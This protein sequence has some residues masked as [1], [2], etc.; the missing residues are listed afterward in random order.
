MKNLLRPV[1]V[2]VLLVGWHAVFCQCIINSADTTTGFTPNSPAIIMPGVP[3]SQT[4]QV[5]VPATYNVYTVDS[6]HIDSLTGQPSGI[7][8][9]LNPASGTVPGGSGGA[10]CFTGTT[11]D[12]V[13]PYPLTF[14]GLAYTNGG[15]IPFSYLTTLDPNFG[16]KFRIETAPAAIFTVDSPL[17][18]NLDTVKFVDHTTGYPTHWKWTFTGGTPATSTRQFPAVVYAS[19]G[20]YPVKFVA[21]NSISN[22]T[23][24]DT[25]TV[26]PSVYVDVAARPA[27]GD[28]SASNGSAIAIPNGGTPP[29]NYAWSNGAYGDTMMNVTSGIYMLT[30][31]DAK[32]CM[33]TNDSVVI[34]FVFDG[35]VQLSAKQQVKIYPNPVSDAINL[36]WPQP[37]NAEIAVIDLNGNVVRKFIS[38]GLTGNTYDIHGLASGAYIIRITDKTSNQQQS[39]LF[40]KF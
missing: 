36:V 33:Y 13:G 10:I 8:Y 5:Y 21:G 9:V 38:G 4:V 31:T 25:I 14:Y 3:Y 2:I 16:Y 11:N 18:S 24:Y 30:T 40:S 23:I 39:V 6:L 26:N 19:A 7:S 27:I 28:S 1:F 29:F 17:C 34:A 35:V 20:T 32:G 22:D 12:T 15:P 37:S